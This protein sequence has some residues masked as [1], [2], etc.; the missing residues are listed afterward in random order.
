VSSPAGSTSE[1]KAIRELVSIAIA[2]PRAVQLPY[3]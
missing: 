3:R 2:D 1:K